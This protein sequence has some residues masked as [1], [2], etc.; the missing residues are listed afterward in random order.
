MSTF[1]KGTTIQEIEAAYPGSIQ[2]RTYII[3][4][5][6]TG[7]GLAFAK[8]VVQHGAGTVVLTGRSEEKLKVALEDVKSV[9][10]PSTVVKTLRMDLESFD[11]VRKAAEEITSGRLDIPKIDV[12]L[13]NAGI[14]AV[15]YKKVEGYERHFVCNYLSHFL[16]TNLILSH[17]SSGARIII[18]SA[19]AHQFCSV[20]FDDIN[21]T[22]GE[23]YNKWE[24]YGQSAS[25][26][27]LFAKALT[28]RFSESKGIQSFSIHPG[29]ILG[30]G[31]TAHVDLAAE[32]MV[33][34]QGNLKYP[35]MTIE[36]GIATYLYAAIS[37]E[38]SGKGGAY[39]TGCKITDTHFQLTNEDAER[40]WKLANE[41][42]KTEF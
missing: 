17:L 18:T 24:A 22:D 12:L 16:F 9:A 4:G 7:L 42:L 37:T 41:I 20:R 11:S 15:P 2:G 40:L 30:T 25:A 5:G 3:T 34:E 13:N 31:I 10:R 27:I 32:G 8:F 39:L 33:D 35:V 14:M 36:Q 21:F 23:E 28:N 1:N 38:L 29:S 6:N 26:N 19:N